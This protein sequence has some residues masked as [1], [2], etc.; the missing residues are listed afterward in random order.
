MKTVFKFLFLVVFITHCIGLSAQKKQVTVTQSTVTG[1]TLP[2]GSQ[3][4]KRWMSENAAK[5]L[6][7]MESK[8]AKTKVKNPEVLYLPSVASCGFNTDSLVAQLSGL[9][10]EILPVEGDNKFAWLQKNGRYVIAYFFMEKTQT[11]MYFAE[12]VAVP[13][14]E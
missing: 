14:M 6:L 9:G 8:K 12:S 3:Q 10:W 7:E 4:D 11:Q 2:A 13:T 5:V 1:I